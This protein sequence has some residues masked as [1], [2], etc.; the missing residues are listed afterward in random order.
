MNKFILLLA[1]FILTV[2]GCGKFE[3]EILISKKQIQEKLDARFPYDKNAVVARFTLDSARVY[4]KEDK[5]GFKLTFYGNFL[6]KEIRGQVDF[7]GKIIYKKENGAFYLNDFEIAEISV[8]E[9]NFSQKSNLE[10]VILKIIQNYL[11]D[12]PICTLKQDDFKQSVA[13]LVLKSVS[14]RDDNLVV[15][16]AL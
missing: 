6:S 1:L 3:K 8:N 5:I 16:I 15:L 10:A 11:D 14:V 9:S 13:T 4:F 7:N 2:S 12:Y